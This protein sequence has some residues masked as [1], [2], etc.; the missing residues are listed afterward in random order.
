MQEGEG[1]GDG[2]GDG[3]G[4][5]GEPLD[6]RFL[7]FANS[8]VLEPTR[9]QLARAATNQ[10]AGCSV[11]KNAT[12]GFYVYKTRYPPILGRW[13]AE[14]LD[15]LRRLHPKRVH[16]PANATHFFPAFDVSAEYGWIPESHAKLRFYAGSER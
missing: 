16:D 10:A 9:A 8:S 1:G 2:G 15:I 3:G 5:G 14:I 6:E 4:G 7:H 11:P 12:F 13:Y